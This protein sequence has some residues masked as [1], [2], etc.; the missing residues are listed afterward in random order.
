ME[1]FQKKPS[2]SAQDEINKA[3]GHILWGNKDKPFSMR[4]I[5]TGFIKK[6]LGGK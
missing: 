3:I 1:E 5:I 4:R 2:Y 6:K